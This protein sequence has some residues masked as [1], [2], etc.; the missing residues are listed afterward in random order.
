MLPT[1]AKEGDFSDAKTVD[2]FFAEKKPMY[3]FHAA[4]MSGGIAE[5]QAHP[6]TLMRDN[7]A[8]NL[9]IID[10]A[11]RH[12]AR[13]LLYLASSCCYPRLCPQP[14]SVEH[15]MSGPLEPTNE[16][17]AT[18]KLA[19]IRL[20]QAY[21]AEYDV[22]FV[23]GIPANSFG[24]EDDFDPERA[25]VVGAL[26]QRMHAAKQ[27]GDSSVIVWG[28]GNA[29]REFIF[30]DDLADACIFVME[31]YSSSIPINLGGG[32]DLS[33]RELA[34]IIRG[35]VGFEGE[36]VFDASRADGMPR[37]T[38]DSTPLRALG[39]RPAGV[40]EDSLHKTLHG[41]LDRLPQESIGL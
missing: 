13:K 31:N 22:D 36:L 10:A 35:V 6:A 32:A 20:V 28:S 29:R 16:A 34:E 9:N 18:A 14:M 1:P 25:H 15:L 39:W 17:Y 3:V 40:M 37:K 26:M 24:I 23:A 4:G 33:I 11:H 19:G 21:R 41:Y 7:L 2:R 30:A 8:K 12:G 27:R 38:L 5:N